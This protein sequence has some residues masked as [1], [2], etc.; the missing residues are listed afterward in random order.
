VVDVVRSIGEL[1]QRCDAWRGRGAR[2]GLVPTMGALHEGHVSLVN[3]VRDAG[4]THIVLTIFVNPTQFAA[5]ED[6]SRYPRTF[7]EDLKRCEHAAVDLVFA[8][9]TETM[10]PAGYQTYV[11]VDTMTQALEGSFRPTHFRGVTTIVAKL[12]NA[13]GPCIAAFG[14]KDYQ[15]WRVI[16][17]MA[18]DLEMPVEVLGCPILRE[19][20]GLAMSS[21]NRYLSETDRE[22]ALCLSRGL[23]A[24]GK[25][26]GAGERRAEKLTALV[27]KEVTKGCDRVDYVALVDADD[28]TPVTGQIE[29]SVTLLIAAHLGTTRLID[30]T[31]LVVPRARHS[32][33]NGPA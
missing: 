19:P 12:F 17:T 28:L 11:S 15:Q 32:F 2:V 20:D 18:R 7:D 31:T 26:F 29:R 13:T 24:A 3:E 5:T 33:G 27:S 16:E 14:R 22:R 1:R 30:N 9:D 23:N 25:A 8:P 4:A 21:R 6:L 10:Y